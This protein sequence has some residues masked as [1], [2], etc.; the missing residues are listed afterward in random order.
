MPF[1]LRTG[2]FLPE[3]LSEIV[4]QFPVSAADAFSEAV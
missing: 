1:Y 2:K 3:K 4:V